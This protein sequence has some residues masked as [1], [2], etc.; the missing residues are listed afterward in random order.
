MIVASASAIVT[1]A[2]DRWRGMSGDWQGKK[3]GKGKKENPNVIG[4][5]LRRNILI[6]LV[7]GV[8][9]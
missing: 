5:D 1:T 4:V 8:R 2:K 3:E 9:L 6:V 7:C